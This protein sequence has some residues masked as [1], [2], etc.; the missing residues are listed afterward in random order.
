MANVPGPNIRREEGPLDCKHPALF[1]DTG[2]RQKDLGGRFK[3]V[4]QPVLH[5]WHPGLVHLLGRVRPHLALPLSRLLQPPTDVPGSAA[6]LKRNKALNFLH[7][8]SIMFGD[9]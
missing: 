1:L 5:P 9:D 4:G 2:K 3:L 6:I 8:F 7:H